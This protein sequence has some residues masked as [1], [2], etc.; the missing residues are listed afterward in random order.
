MCIPYG[1]LLAAA[2]LAARLCGWGQPATV[3]GVVGGLQ[4]VLSNLS[5]R[6]WRKGASAAPFT[7][8]EAGKHRVGAGDVEREL[9]RAGT[10]VEGRP[11]AAV[12]DA[13]PR[14]HLPPS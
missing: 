5:L 10:R 2:G 14:S 1:A 8:V 3:M 4:V 11:H 9:C 13:Q 6:A 12:A 7:L